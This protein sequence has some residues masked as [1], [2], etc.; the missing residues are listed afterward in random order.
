MRH[1][2]KKIIIIIVISMITII[3][4]VVSESVPK[5]YR[6]SQHITVIILLTMNG[7]IVDW[8]WCVCGFSVPFWMCNAD[9]ALAERARQIRNSYT[10]RAY[11]Y[12]AGARLLLGFV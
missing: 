11:V 12:E 8:R 5:L 1:W 6:N 9:N 4:I 2:E 3:V 7:V 10:N